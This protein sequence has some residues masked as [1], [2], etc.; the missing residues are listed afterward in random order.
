VRRRDGGGV[1]VGSVAIEV[2]GVAERIAVWIARAGAVELHG[3]R[4]RA[5][6]AVRARDG[7]GRLVHGEI[8]D[9]LDAASVEVDVVEVSA[10]T[11]LQAHGT[12][13]KACRERDDVAGIGR[14]QAVRHHGPDAPAGVIGEEERTIVSGGVAAA[15]IERETGHG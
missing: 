5:A 15:P 3:Q 8:A 2:P 13:R 11:D 12:A 7:R 14:P 4:R 1:V 9:A 6:G 10:G